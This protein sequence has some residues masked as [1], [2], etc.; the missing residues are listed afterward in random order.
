M[1]VGQE[2]VCV[3]DYFPGP[4]AKYYTNLPV[5]GKTYTIRAVFIGRRVMHTKPGAADGEIG[6]LLQELINGQDPR[7]KHGQE[8]GFNAERFRP[9]ETMDTSTEN[10]DELV[11]AGSLPEPEKEPAPFGTV[12]QREILGCLPRSRS[13]WSA[14]YSAA[15]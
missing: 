7:N 5:K 8:L 13:V 15:G 11:M 2:V 10:E 12:T 6:V 9:L 4:L 14:A 1:R 3:D